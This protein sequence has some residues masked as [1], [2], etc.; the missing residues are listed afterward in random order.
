M[1]DQEIIQEFLVESREN[2][3][4][5]DG[6]LVVLEKDPRDSGRLGS[7]F[8]T[9][10]TIKG[11]CGF[12][13]FDKL[14]NVTH[15]GESLLARLR[16]GHLILKPEI[17]TALLA[18][19]DMVRRFLSNIE[20]TGHEGPEEC[21]ELVATLSRLKGGSMILP[22]EK[23]GSRR[24]ATN[25]RA[26]DVA[27]N[28]A[29]NPAAPQLAA[30]HA[31]EQEA[32]DNRA[33]NP[34]EGNIR[35]DVGLLDR[36]MNLVG[37][38]VLARNQIVQYSASREDN[39]LAG[40]VQRLDQIA[41]ELQEGVMKTRMQPIANVWNKFPRLARDLAL[42]CGKQV[43]LTLEGADT[44]LDRTILEAIKDPL[45]HLV[46]NAID[47]GIETPEARR[48]RGKPPEGRVSLRAFHE[49][50]RVHIEV[51]DDGAGISTERIKRRA[52]EK[53]LLTR[54]ELDQLNERQALE[55]IFLPG[56]STAERVTSVSGRGVGMDVVKT[57]VAKIGGVLE[58]QSRPAQGTLVKIT[59]PLTLAI[60]PAFIVTCC[61][62]RFA[63]PQGSVLELVR[64]DPDKGPG[65][66]WLND[67]PVYRLRGKLLPVIDLG[68]ALKLPHGPAT[69]INLVIL[70]AGERSFG[71]AVDRVN[72]T[73]EIVVKPLGK[74][75]GHS[76]L[77]AG[78]TIL[79]DGHVVLI[80][81]VAGIAQHGR[82]VQEA[83]RRVL[84][85][86][87]APQAPGS[88]GRLL[89]LCD[90]DGQRRVALPFDKLQRL[91][92]IAA[93]AVEKTIDREMVQCRGEA[94]PLIRLSATLS[95]GCSPVATGSA[96]LQVAMYTDGARKVGI[97]VERILDI[98]EA[99]AE[100]EQGTARG[101]IV[102]TAVICGRVTDLIDVPALLS[103]HHPASRRQ[104]ASVGGG[105]S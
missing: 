42:A 32:S 11:T 84:T 105:A 39:V 25:E 34:G 36:L 41:T 26:A 43:C 67:T 66:E 15:A 62:E 46:R 57:H 79:G 58:L 48:A 100:R 91:E 52:L 9:I 68:K 51:A 54:A 102:N 16:D 6:D 99:E 55:L 4:Q 69:V 28:P 72:D 93:S 37:E 87:A 78:A 8:R 45:T 82:V 59:I 7:V 33:G 86:I 63:I 83:R 13:G 61:G 30:E 49:G 18:L 12:L 70:Q 50:G 95:G 71:L 23:P 101:P 75:L 96:S 29:L 31:A 17:T 98:V 56:L 38:L 88:V 60:I 21:M 19:V 22:P 94:V 1:N 40:M 74:L 103:A 27:V 89:L 5:L 10:H 64:L 80:L 85:E 76:P 14:E 104:C 73:Q 97:V 44:E 20:A 65:I 77:Y 81:D 90:L 47:H 53:A 92:E 35:V 24:G 3:D 2:L